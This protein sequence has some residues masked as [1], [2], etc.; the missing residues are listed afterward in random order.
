MSYISE[1]STELDAIITPTSTISTFLGWQQT[2]SIPLF[3][4]T[5][6]LKSAENTSTTLPQEVT[7][8]PLLSKLWLIA[9]LLCAGNH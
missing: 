2:S 8:V 9:T 1:A 6:A 5:I 3:T 4:K 7:T